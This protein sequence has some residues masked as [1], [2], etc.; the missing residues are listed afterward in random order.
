MTTTIPA[1]IARTQ[2][3]SILAQVSKNKARFIITKSGKPTAVIL[4]A[5]IFDDM[6]E[7]LDQEFQK[8]LKDAAREIRAG[9]KV[10]L[11]EY[12][13]EQIGTPDSK[14]S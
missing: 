6:V 8:S 13:K 10:T 9:K 12:L 3:G 5:S 2:L 1:Y 4:N 7:E 14:R 11:R